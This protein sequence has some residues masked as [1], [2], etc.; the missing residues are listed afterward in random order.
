MTQQG[1]S[2]ATQGLLLTATADTHKRQLLDSIAAARDHM[3]RN[4]KIYNGLRLGLRITKVLRV[5]LTSTA[6]V[7]TGMSKATWVAGL[8]AGGGILTALIEF[9][10]REFDTDG[11]RA[12]Y[13]PYYVAFRQQCEDLELE[14]HVEEEGLKTAP[15]VPQAGS[16]RSQGPAV[17]AQQGSPR[18]HASIRGSP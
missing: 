1:N 6:A 2:H 17:A 9:T 15:A 13:Y 8:T 4:Y 12:H 10:D 5:P 11:M 3:D 18:C 7:V 14:S 16:P